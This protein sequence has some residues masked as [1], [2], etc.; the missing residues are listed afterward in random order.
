MLYALNV[1]NDVCQLLLNKTGGKE[2]KSNLARGITLNLL[3]KVFRK[4]QHFII[5]D[6]CLD[7]YNLD[8]SVFQRDENADLS[9]FF[10]PFNF[11]YS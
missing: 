1:Y 8:T 4:S 10:L 3:Y 7:T 11:D 6:K 5:G 2:N 9:P